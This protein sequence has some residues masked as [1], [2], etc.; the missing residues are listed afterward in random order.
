M[1]KAHGSAT[2]DE[3]QTMEV[4]VNKEETAAAGAGE[5]AGAQATASGAAGKPIKPQVL[6]V[7]DDPAVR[8][9]V[10]TTLEAHGYRTA[11]AATGEAGIMAAASRN[12]ELVLLDLGL[13]DMDG[14]DVIRRLRTWSTVPIIVLSARIEDAD[15]VA[16]LD[17]GADDY[18]TK[19]FSVEELLARVRAS[20]RRGGWGHGD[21]A[22]SVYVN[23]DLKI[24]F[25]ASTAWM[26]GKELTLTSTEYK[27]LCVLARNTNKVLTHNYIMKQVW[28]SAW[29]GSVASL[30]VFMRSLRK[31]IEPD[32]AHP[33]YIQTRIGV[34]YRMQAQQ[35]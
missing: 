30:R 34:G 10:E 25:S 13:P 35:H 20:L 11:S 18:L 24:D 29:D 19:P 17:A 6:L 31:K 4:D 14:N 22:E 28:G 16:A 23:G 32:S 12:P 15:K 33:R 1:Q 5:T 21:E 9:L 7:E 3:P 26:A 8:S 27:L 2:G